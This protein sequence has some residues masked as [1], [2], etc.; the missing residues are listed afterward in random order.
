MLLA[1][2]GDISVLIVYIIECLST[3]EYLVAWA[4]ASIEKAKWARW[5][6]RAPSFRERKGSVASVNST[7]KGTFLLFGIQHSRLMKCIS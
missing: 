3:T 1:S 7:Q 4:D 2:L 6:R 5:A